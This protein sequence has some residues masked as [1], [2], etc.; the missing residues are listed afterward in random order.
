MTTKTTFT[1]PSD[2]SDA[3]RIA[4]YLDPDDIRW[5][6]SRCECD[7]SATDNEREHCAR[8]RFRSSTAMHKAKQ[9]IDF[10]TDCHFVANVRMLTEQ[11]GGR[12]S[13]IHTGYRS[14]VFL[15]GE[16]CDA[17]IT[18]DGETLNPGD[19]GIVFGVLMRPDRNCGKLSVG[20][21]LLL[22]E[23]ARTIAYGVIVWHARSA[24]NPMHG[25]GEVG[26]I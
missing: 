25:S 9:T 18:I 15:D 19:V 10:P 5:L 7:D 23:G 20:K 11:T 17:T 13:A 22:R 6:S 24:N 21:P 16:D 4:V 12:K 3:G 1:I 14:Q 2:E 8:I 26:R